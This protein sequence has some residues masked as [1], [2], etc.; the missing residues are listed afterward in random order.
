MI[1]SGGPYVLVKAVVPTEEAPLGRPPLE[2]Q[3]FEILP[4]DRVGDD[5]AVVR[6]TDSEIVL[7][8]VMSDLRFSKLLVVVPKT[9][10]VRKLPRENRGARRK[11][12]ADR[13]VTVFKNGSF[14]AILLC[15]IM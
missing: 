6:E 8:E 3:K 9:V 15:L 11:G 14:S 7:S 10:V 4:R 1:L 13:R 5:I 2:A 12:P